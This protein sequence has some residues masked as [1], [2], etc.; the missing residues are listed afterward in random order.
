MCVCVCSGVSVRC[1]GDLDRALEALGSYTGIS[2]PGAGSLPLADA[3][4]QGLLRFL[5]VLFV[6]CATAASIPAVGI[7]PVRFRS[8]SVCSRSVDVK[9]CC[10]DASDCLVVDASPAITTV[11]WCLAFEV[12]CLAP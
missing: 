1:S 4:M 3:A 10:W 11:A 2:A 7:Q 8:M 9:K 5:S 12:C 6:A